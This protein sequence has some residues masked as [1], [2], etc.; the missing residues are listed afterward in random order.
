MPLKPCWLQI[1]RSAP[2]MPLSSR[3]IPH[4]NSARPRIAN[5]SSRS[6]SGGSWVDEFAVVELGGR[7]FVGLGQ[8]EAEA[9]GGL[10]LLDLGIASFPVPKG[11]PTT[12]W[13]QSRHTSTSIFPKSQVDGL[14]FAAA[15]F[16]E[17]W[18]LRRAAEGRDSNEGDFP[19]LCHLTAA[20]RRL[21][22]RWRKDAAKNSSEPPLAGRLPPSRRLS[23]TEAS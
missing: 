18:C 4:A 10:R 17:L 12:S 19:R 6:S 14:I 3:P 5:L 21:G 2:P 9:D 11:T 13:P 16:V 22:M 20:V 7:S 1:G 23:T 15:L 8:R